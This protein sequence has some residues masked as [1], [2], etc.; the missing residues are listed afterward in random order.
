MSKAY[1]I[2]DSQAMGKS[3][4]RSHKYTVVLDAGHGV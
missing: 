1:K 4:S 2:V 3:I